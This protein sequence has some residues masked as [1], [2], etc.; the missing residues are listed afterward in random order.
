MH[1][2]GFT[3]IHF[4]HIPRTCAVKS[5]CGAVAINFLRSQV[6]VF[7]RL[8][9][10]FSAW[11]EHHC[12]QRRFIQHVNRATEVPRPW[13]WGS[14]PDEGEAIIVPAVGLLYLLFRPYKVVMP[15]KQDCLHNLI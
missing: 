4:D 5:V 1:A 10:N 14:G 15:V 7:P 6:A 12:L 13:F 3:E 8:G 11:E 9:T 2:L